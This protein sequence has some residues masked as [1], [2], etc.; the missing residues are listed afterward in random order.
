M[1]RNFLLLI[2]LIFGIL[3]ASY[4]PLLQHVI[5]IAGGYSS[6]TICSGIFISKRPMESMV[7]N[8]LKGITAFLM[9]S[10]VDYVNHTVTS[11]L[12]GINNP[13]ILSFFGLKM[14]TAKF[15]GKDYGCQLIIEPFQSIS[16][17]PQGDNDK[18]KKYSHDEL[19]EM[20]EDPDPINKLRKK[21]R[22]ELHWD[23]NFP[24][25]QKS[26]ASEFTSIAM[27][28]NQTRAIVISHRGEI[29]YER[30]QSLMNITADTPL[31]GWSMTKS[32]LAILI[33]IGIQH[34]LLT[35]DT[36]LQLSTLSEDHKKYLRERNHG[37]DLTFRSLLN[38]Q[39]I[40]LIEED[41]ST[42]GP[43]PHFLY[44]VH[45]ITQFVNKFPSSSSSSSSSS[46]PAHF[47]S[48]SP[49]KDLPFGWYYSSA[50][51]NLLSAEFRALFP[52]DADY[53]TF[54]SQALYKPLSLDSFLIELDPSGTFIASSF[55]YGTARDW[56]K[57][58]DLLLNDGKIRS[59]D[60]DVDPESLRLLPSEYVKFLMTTTP[61]SGG[62]YGGHVWMNPSHATEEISALLPA[63]HERRK[64][65]KWLTDESHPEGSSTLKSSAI[66]SDAVF[67][68]GYHGQYVLIVPSQEMVITRL[69]MT[70]NDDKIW[71]P[72]EFFGTILGKCWK[73]K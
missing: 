5:H 17:P 73:G 68:S 10:H 42:L 25:L 65:L 3:F 43:V 56:N 28:R 35:L 36:P 15:L 67:F 60:R 39:D 49:T 41:Y 19:D 44:G 22:P 69:G 31:L 57:L 62:F 27:K 2:F 23:L 47:S 51:T 53:W 58:G 6:K 70:E 1:F 54:P 4:Y 48:P 29:V 20:F 38:M 9:R 33:G 18:K 34:N 45:D 59:R 12:F 52:S 50:V 71:N 16:P 8:E 37:Q 63:D 24:C 30:Y 46:S 14:I 40:L 72:K 13:E 7:S 66:P 64:Q 21:F 11:S 26:L 32:I 55:G 61:L